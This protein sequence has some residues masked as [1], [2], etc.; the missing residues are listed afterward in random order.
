MTGTLHP[1]NDLVRHAEGLD[2]SNF[3]VLLE[4]MTTALSIQDRGDN[5]SDFLRECADTA[6]AH[7]DA[8]GMDPGAAV[9][10]ILAK[11]T[12]GGAC[13]HPTTRLYS[14]FARD[15]TAPDGQVLCVCCSQCGA[16]LTGG[17]E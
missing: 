11:H 13:Q 10:P 14:W 1:V 16:I 7:V 4:I 15:D 9:R 6:K 17:A 12:A 2:D 3:G 5:P 8:G